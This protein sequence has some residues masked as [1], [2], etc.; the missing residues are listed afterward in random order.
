MFIHPPFFNTV[1]FIIFLPAAKFHLSSSPLS[2]SSHPAPATTQFGLPNVV[3]MSF[4]ITSS[5]SSIRHIQ[6]SSFVILLGLLLSGDIQLNP[7][8]TSSTFNICTLNIR[9][10]LNPLKYT[11]MSDLADT[12]NIDVFALTETWITPSATPSE[13]RNVIL[14]RASSSS[15]ILV[16]LL[17]IMRMLLVEAPLFFFGTQLSLLS[18]RPVLPSRLLNSLLSPSNFS[19]LS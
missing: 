8:P 1:L 6:S 15:V 18:H 10:L 11:A 2:H 3:P 13:L 19:T 4:F 12:R 5:K 9:S 17:P 16:L 7:G 14:R